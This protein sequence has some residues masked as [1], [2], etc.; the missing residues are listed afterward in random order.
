MTWFMQDKL[1]SAR[2]GTFISLLKQLRNQQFLK[3]IYQAMGNQGTS[4]SFGLQPNNMLHMQSSIGLKVDQI[5][6][7][8][9]FERVTPHKIRLPHHVKRPKFP[10]AQVV[11]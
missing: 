7:E 8:L 2:K 9:S 6:H 11:G 10:K 4:N 1:S 3:V 5:K